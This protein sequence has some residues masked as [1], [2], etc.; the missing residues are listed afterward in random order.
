[1]KR[2]IGNNDATPLNA[3]K[4]YRELINTWSTAFAEQITNQY[5]LAQQLNNRE[6]ENKI[7]II[8]EDFNKRFKLLQD[9]ENDILASQSDWEFTQ[10]H[11]QLIITFTIIEDAFSEALET[12]KEALEAIKIESIGK[13]III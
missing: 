12:I 1:L 5:F 2:Y 3:L 8:A 9:L 11:N 4:N 13:Q 6:L 7:E 10:K